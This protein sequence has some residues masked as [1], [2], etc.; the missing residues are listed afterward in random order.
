MSRQTFL[1]LMTCLTLFL[2]LL[3]CDLLEPTPTPNAIATD[4]AGTKTVWARATLV[5]NT[6]MAELPKETPTPI[7]PTP[8]FTPLPTSTLLPTYIPLPTYT[9]LPTNTPWPTNTPLPTRLT[10]PI[11]GEVVCSSGFDAAAQKPINPSPNK[12]LTAMTTHLWASFPF[13]VPDMFS[14]K[15]TC[16]RMGLSFPRGKTS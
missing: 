16:T 8:T 9:P 1:R 3:A 10:A 4:V 2:L 7:P 15:F 6:L 11:F 5:A 13:Q 14:Y 12:I